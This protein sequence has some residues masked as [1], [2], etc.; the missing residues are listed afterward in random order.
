MLRGLNLV[1]CNIPMHTAVENMLSGFVHEI[2]TL[3]VCS[4]QIFL[5]DWYLKMHICVFDNCKI[6]IWNCI[7]ALF[8]SVIFVWFILKTVILLYYLCVQFLKDRYLK[9]HQGI[10]CVFNIWRIDIWKCIKALFVC[11]RQNDPAVAPCWA[12]DHFGK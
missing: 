10:I 2:F 9:I 11:L 12:S 4:K 6:D 1:F 8:V 7:W 3:V 5:I